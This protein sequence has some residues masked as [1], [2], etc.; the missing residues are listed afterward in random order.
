M[1]WL[2]DIVITLQGGEVDGVPGVRG[3][4]CAPDTGNKNYRFE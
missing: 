1:S 2:P 4:E 3:R